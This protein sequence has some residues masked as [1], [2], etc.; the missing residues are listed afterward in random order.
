MPKFDCKQCARIAAVVALVAVFGWAG[1][2]WYRSRDVAL[3]AAVIINGPVATQTN[4]PTA[5]TIAG[6]PFIKSF[7]KLN[8]FHVAIIRSVVV[9]HIA[10][11]FRRS[12]I[13][14]SNLY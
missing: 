6:N 11:L 14:Q 9:F 3:D 4:L 10:S 8:M 7:Y 2:A 13:Q 1:Y 12:L 5:F